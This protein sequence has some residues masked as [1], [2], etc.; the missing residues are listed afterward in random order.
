MSLSVPCFIA[1]TDDTK[2]SYFFVFNSSCFRYEAGADEDKRAAPFLTKR[3]AVLD[4][5][6]A[7][8]K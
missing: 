2:Y 3:A 7:L 4:Q 5:L 6:C 8:G 1:V